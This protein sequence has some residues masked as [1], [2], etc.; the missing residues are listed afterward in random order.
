ML[1]L[2]DVHVQAYATLAA[3]PESWLSQVTTRDFRRLLAD[4]TVEPAGNDFSVVTSRPMIDDPFVLL[5]LREL[6]DAVFGYNKSP[7]LVRLGRFHL[8]SLLTSSVLG[9]IEMSSHK[10]D[11]HHTGLHATVTHAD[12]AHHI[13]GQDVVT[14]DCQVANGYTTIAAALASLSSVVPI[15]I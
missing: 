13:V 4:A 15:F 11:E 7:T 3:D 9:G 6:A 10:A 8:L 2:L 5:P 1:L 12:P 14:V